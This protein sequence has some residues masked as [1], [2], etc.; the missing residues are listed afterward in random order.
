MVEKQNIPFPVLSDINGKVIND[1]NIV[2]QMSDTLCSPVLKHT[3]LDISRVNGDSG[4][5][6][7]NQPLLLLNN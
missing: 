3:Q 6:L 5:L 4:W 2:F 7:T 1:Y